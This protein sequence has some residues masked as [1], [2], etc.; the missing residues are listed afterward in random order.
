MKPFLI[1]SDY[2][3]LSLPQTNELYLILAS[4]QSPAP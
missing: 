4:K 2:I 3:D 1:T